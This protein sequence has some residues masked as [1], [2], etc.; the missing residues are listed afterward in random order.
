MKPAKLSTAGRAG[1]GSGF[2]GISPALTFAAA[3]SQ[4]SRSL[5]EKSPARRES[6]LSPPLL[7]FAL[8][9]AMQFLVTNGRT[10]FENDGAV[11]P[12]AVAAAARAT[13]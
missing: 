10:V 4:I 1:R 5:V 2:G 13:E 6:K 12:Q 9:Q 11:A 7:V 3:F 8:W